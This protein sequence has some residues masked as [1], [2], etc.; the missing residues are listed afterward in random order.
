MVE[1]SGFAAG[2]LLIELD[3]PGLHA[4]GKYPITTR[5][6]ERPRVPVLDGTD[7][8]IPGTVG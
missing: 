5:Q 3:S 4:N 7:A 1:G 8:I 6:R 2:G